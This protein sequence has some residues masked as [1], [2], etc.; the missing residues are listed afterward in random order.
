[1][2]VSTI[3]KTIEPRTANHQPR[4]VNRELSTANNCEPRTVNRE[5]RTVNR[6]LVTANREP[7]TVN[8]Q[9]RTGNCEPRAVSLQPRTTNREPSTVNCQPRTGNLFNKLSDLWDWW[10]ITEYV[11]QTYLIILAVFNPFLNFQF[12]GSLDQTKNNEKKMKKHVW[13]KNQ[14]FEFYCKYPSLPVGP[15]WNLAVRGSRFAVRGWRLAVRGSRFA[16]PCRFAD[17]SI[18][19][20][21]KPNT[22]TILRQHQQVWSNLGGH[23]N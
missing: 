10:I 15:F 23:F 5:P 2:L 13:K 7:P 8:C 6:D 17:F 21:F 20:K 19:G 22:L 12:E 14:I 3:L 9:P 18:R 16:V 11:I 1:M 4:T